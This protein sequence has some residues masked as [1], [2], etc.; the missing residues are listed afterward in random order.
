MITNA[1]SIEMNHLECDR[2]WRSPKRIRDDVKVLS[3]FEVFDEEV[4]LHRRP[5]TRHRIQQ[6]RPPIRPGI[7][8]MRLPASKFMSA[9]SVVLTSRSFTNTQEPLGLAGLLGNLGLGHDNLGVTVYVGNLDHEGRSVLTAHKAGIRMRCGRSCQDVG[10][11]DAGRSR[12][13]EP[14]S[15]WPSR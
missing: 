1:L 9:M 12:T 8:R 4:F 2:R 13:P 5:R 10:R 7:K 11:A 15:G 14:G 6:A 3:E